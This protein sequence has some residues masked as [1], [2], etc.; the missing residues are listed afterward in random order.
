MIYF[1]LKQNKYIMK[2]NKKF[3][4]EFYIDVDEPVYTSGI[5]VR[6]LDIPVWILKQLDK[7]GV[8]CPIRKKKGSCRLYSK[9]ELSYL[10][11]CWEYISEK[12]VNVK[13]LKVILDMEKELKG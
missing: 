3:S 6:L 1:I 10:A 13:G 4:E 12:G 9:R 11:H 8:V 5:V 2:K 7:E